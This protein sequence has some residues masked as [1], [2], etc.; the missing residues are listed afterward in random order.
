MKL[1]E[2]YS[3]S[4]GLKIGKQFLLEKYYP[5]KNNRYI[6]I[7]SGSGMPGKNY[8][9]YGEVINLILPVLKSNNIDIIQLGGPE[10]QNLSNCINLNGKTNLHQT[11]YILSRSLLFIGNDSWIQHRAGE[12]NIPVISLFGSTSKSNHS[13]YKYNE[14]SI[15]LESHRFDKKT[16]FIPKENPQTIS[17]I[18]PEEV[19]NAFFKIFNLNLACPIETIFI[20]SLYTQQ[21]IEWVPNHILPNININSQSLITRCDYAENSDFEAY[22]YNALKVKSLYIIT[23]KI[24]NFDILKEC[25]KNISM[26]IF[27]LNE[28]IDIDYIKNVKRLG[29]KIRLTSEENDENLSKLRFKYLETN[30]I[31][32]IIF[33]TKDNFISES[34]IFLN[35]KLDKETAFLDNNKYWIK[36]NKF[37]LSDNKIFP[38]KFHLKNNQNIPSFEHS[39]SSFHDSKF[40]W[41]E[42][43]HFYIFKEKLN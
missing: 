36:S 6:T 23:D 15:F 37:I 10:D 17:F 42:Y 30:V 19:A 33:K 9:Y 2:V 28:K 39:T 7:Q 5:L 11:N 12:L 35:K 4:S 25:K 21:I 18:K 24:I 22:L 8:P 32:K 29:I 34:E 40:I 41:E 20:G 27:S 38:S 13:P 31:E 26:L 43:D 16:T 3:L 14:R 1:A